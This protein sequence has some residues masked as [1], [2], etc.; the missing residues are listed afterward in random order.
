MDPA[1][2]FIETSYIFCRIEEINICMHFVYILV[3]ETNP[4]KI[5]I[6]V[7]NNLDRR[8]LE[9]NEGESR[10]TSLFKPWNLESYI[11]FKSRKTA[12]LFERYL[13]KGSGFAFLKKH[14]LKG[15][16]SS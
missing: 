4:E 1:G 7:T 16:V 15:L 13:K 3:S 5:Y 12:E 11:A 8:L 10:Y 6:G 14:F 9:H 2:F